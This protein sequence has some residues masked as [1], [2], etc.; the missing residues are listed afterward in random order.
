M[1]FLPSALYLL[2]VTVAVAVAAL[3]LAL[4]KGYPLGEAARSAARAGWLCAA[5]FAAGW[6]IG[7]LASLRYGW[8]AI[9]AIAVGG[10]AWTIFRHAGESRRFAGL[11]SAIVAVLIFSSFYIGD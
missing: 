6:V 10:I 2:A 8:G 4:R 7:L 1:P 11:F 9:A 5:F 3:L